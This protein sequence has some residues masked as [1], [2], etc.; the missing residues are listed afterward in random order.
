VLCHV[1]SCNVIDC[2][3]LRH[4]LESYRFVSLFPWSLTSIHDDHFGDDDWARFIETYA[5]SIVVGSTQELYL[6]RALR[7]NDK[8][9]KQVR[10]DVVSPDASADTEMRGSEVVGRSFTPLLPWLGLL[11]GAPPWIP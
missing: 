9:K 3:N 2:Q 5:G 8:Q 1:M 10:L 7:P 11:V 4:D 6:I